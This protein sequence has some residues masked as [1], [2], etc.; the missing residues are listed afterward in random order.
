MVDH[1][2]KP[3]TALVTGAS[4][5]VGSRLSKMLVQAGWNV[6]VIVRPTSNLKLLEPIIEQ[7]HL[8][9]YTNSFASLAQI[10]EKV[11]P[12]VTF[13]LASVAAIQYSPQMIRNMLDCNVTFGTELVEAISSSGTA[14]LV[15]TGTFSQHFQQEDYNPNSLYAASKQAFE[16]ILRYYTET[17]RLKVLTLTLFDNY[18]PLDP[19]PKIMNLLYSA[20]KNGQPLTMTKG[21][22]YLD[23][24]YI[25]DVA[26][27]Y[28]AA[29]DRLLSGQSKAQEKF[30]VS[31]GNRIQLKQ[32]VVEF[33][34]IIGRKLPIIWGGVNYRPREIMIPWNRGIPLPGWQPKV[35]LQEGIQLF[36]ERN[37][38]ISSAK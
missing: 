2:L 9:Y 29:A 36:I 25:D 22:Q 10:A 7:I 13:H 20:Y 21:E 34:N 4:G 35:S 28:I 24:V 26:K 8:H 19:R 12:D 30:A 31:S 14:L 3:L 32:L 1:K 37:D 15:N 5:F 17:N 18:G 23:L 33:E 11:S 6:H 38:E 16:D 27:A